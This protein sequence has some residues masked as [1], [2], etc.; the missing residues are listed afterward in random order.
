MIEIKYVYLSS[1]VMEEIEVVPTHCQYQ[2]K[3][4]REKKI[5]SKSANDKLK[6]Y[7]LLV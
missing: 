2:V 6:N 1:H 4:I 3:F 7:M 5:R